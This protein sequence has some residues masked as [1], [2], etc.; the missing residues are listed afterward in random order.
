MTKSLSMVLIAMCLPFACTKTNPALCCT[1]AANC[2]SLGIS[3]DNMC[4]DG[5]VCV[6]NTCVAESCGTF[7]DCNAALPFCSNSLCEAMC[8]DNSQCP[9][10]G[11]SAEDTICSSGVCVQCVM[12]SDCSGATPV[13][14]SNTCVQCVANS[15]CSQA[16]PIC[17]STNTCVNCVADTD[18]MSDVCG[19][20]GSCVA[21]SAVVYLSPAGSDSG[22][23]TQASPCLSLN[24]G[25]AQTSDTRS[26]MS[27]ANGLYSGEVFLQTTSISTAEIDVHGNGATIA[28]KPGDD[29]PFFEAEISMTLR[30]LVID[31]TQG[32][33]NSAMVIGPGAF[34]LY[35]VTVKGGFHGILSNGPIMAQ[36]LIVEQASNMGISTTAA[37]TID[38]AQIFGMPTGITASGTV[39]LTNVMLHDCSTTAIDLSHG[40]G[41]I[42]FSTIANSGMN[43]GTPSPAVLCGDAGSLRDT[44][45]WSP[46][47]ETQ[48]PVQ[49]C[50]LFQT[51]V[52]PLSIAGA[53]DTDPLFVN[54]T[55]D[56][57]LSSSSPAIDA[58]DTGPPDDFEGD[59]RPQGAR[60]DIGADEYKP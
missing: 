57:H 35:G 34:Q 51:I 42:S 36:D 6:A 44:I 48:A 4:T 39:A 11:G 5:L 2:Q 40:N 59:A 12:N 37:L 30:D 29:G 28:P 27:L 17:S 14:N 22:T 1:D 23:C 15:D 38:R 60:Y 20:D 32:D 16:A 41:T 19:S 53:M 58:V 43:T 9:G 54:A 45:V 3:T 33:P 46:A 55:S 13:C 7:A 52:G 8:D 49:G 56:F 50:S 25:A 31:A 18:C 47:L 26:T 21:A 10:F 24:Y